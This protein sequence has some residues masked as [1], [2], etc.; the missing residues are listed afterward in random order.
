MLLE[1]ER[2]SEIMMRGR[3]HQK[4]PTYERAI[5]FLY[6][7]LAS[8][9]ER[10]LEIYRDVFWAGIDASTTECLSLVR[11]LGLRIPQDGRYGGPSRPGS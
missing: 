10:E 7:K 6:P 8:A 1:F 11:E 3:E 2:F 9:G 4:T 5:R